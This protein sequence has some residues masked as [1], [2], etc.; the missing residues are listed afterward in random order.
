MDNSETLATL[1]SQDEDKQNKNKS[2]TQH[3]KQEQHRPHQNPRVNPV[4]C[5]ILIRHPHAPCYL[6]IIAKSNKSRSLLPFFWKFYSLT[7]LLILISSVSRY[8]SQSIHVYTNHQ[9]SSRVYLEKSV[10]LIYSVFCS[11]T[12]I[13]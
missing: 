11:S 13:S 8:A 6:H 7:R 2:K 5:S 9:V 3:R 12:C 1:V 10:F 4:A